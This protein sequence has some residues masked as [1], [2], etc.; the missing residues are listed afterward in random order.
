MRTETNWSPTTQQ[1]TLTRAGRG[2]GSSLIITGLTL[3]ASLLLYSLLGRIGPQVLGFYT[4]LI[5]LSGVL[6]TFGFFGDS[7]VYVRYIPQLERSQK[8]PFIVTHTVI[9]LIQGSLVIACF[10]LFPR[11]LS[12]LL[13][14]AADRSL[15]IYSSILAV[16]LFTQGVASS[17]LQSVLDTGWH[18]LGQKIPI[19]VS[20]AGV[21]LLLLLAPERLIINYRLTLMVVIVVGNA[22]G[23]AALVNRAWRLF[24]S[25]LPRAIHWYLPADFW[26]FS[27][28]LQLNTVATFMFLN[29]DQVLMASMFSITALGEYKALLSI[30]ELVRQIPLVVGTTAYPLL[31]HLRSAGCNTST[32][33][34]A[35][36]D[37]L[38]MISAVIA[39]F[40]AAFAADFLRIIYGPSYVEVATPLGLLS[41]GYCLTGVSIV[42]SAVLIAHGFSAR[43]FIANG[44]AA[45]LQLGAS[46]YLGNHFGI[47]GIAL[48]R[49][50]SIVLNLVLLW[51]CARRLVRVV[52]SL[53]LVLGLM[54]VACLTVVPSLSLA[55]RIAV[56]LLI[57]L[58]LLTLLRRIAREDIIRSLLAALP[59]PRVIRTRLELY[60]V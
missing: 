45:I 24:I 3:P 5:I 54:L 48:G 9:V 19:L 14:S 4:L 26:R 21:I 13:G 8:L 38:F 58:A 28:A 43:V 36:S 59:I 46:L 47:T 49:I 20:L 41:I 35:I 53:N 33:A 10:I 31:A 22:A 1:D 44:I 15:A 6:M 17:V 40:C 2:I 52:P 39:V 30:A 18:A 34:V 32:E 57:E 55:P 23:V 7:Y 29:L 12:F 51:F 37:F 42:A 25:Q 56:A 27:I 50:L 60:G 16:L 11:A